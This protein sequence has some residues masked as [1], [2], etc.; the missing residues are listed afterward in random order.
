VTAEYHPTEGG[1][2]RPNSPCPHKPGSAG[3][4]YWLVERA[5][6]GEPLFRK[7]DAK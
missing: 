2:F 4:V 6:V 7:D 5:A 3:K 1:K